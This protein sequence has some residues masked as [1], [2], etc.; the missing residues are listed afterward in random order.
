LRDCSV[1]PV[2]QDETLQG[3]NLRWKARTGSHWTLQPALQIDPDYAPLRPGVR[4][5]D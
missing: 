3:D 4:A 5:A 1:N 2:V